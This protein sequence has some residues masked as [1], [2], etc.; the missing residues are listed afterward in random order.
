[1]GAKGHRNQWKAMAAALSDWGLKNQRRMPWRT[2]SNEYE[3][4]V[5]EILLQ[6]T[7][8]GDVLPVWSTLLEVYPSP[9]SLATSDD[10]QVLTIVKQ[11]GLGNQRVERLKAM[12]AALT[13]KTASRIPGLGSYGTG[14]L[15]LSR[16]NS[17]NSPPVD[18]NISRLMCRLK[19]LTFERGEPRKKPEVKTAVAE[20]LA[21]QKSAK[22]KLQL[23]Y[24]MVDLGA[25]V[26]K[27]G[28]PLCDDCPVS[29]WCEFS[30]AR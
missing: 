17:L 3:L 15:L 23:V 20:L 30:E 10:S 11:L 6:K 9:D 26:C 24:A 4:A 13:E 1:M 19:G 12:A 21:V 14:I 8:G 7:K 28:T 22:Q 18:G 16:G 5:A 29:E 25:S 27:A 2:R